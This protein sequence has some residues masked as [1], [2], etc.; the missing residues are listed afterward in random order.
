MNPAEIWQTGTRYYYFSFAAR[1][2][3]P[4]AKLKALELIAAGASELIAKPWIFGG[5]E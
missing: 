2:V 5:A 1:R 4:I 3:M